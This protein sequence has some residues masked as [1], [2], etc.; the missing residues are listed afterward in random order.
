MS[1]SWALL[2]H[3]CLW[4]CWQ[5]LNFRGTFISHASFLVLA[6]LASEPSLDLRG[7]P[8]TLRWGSFPLQTQRCSN[9][10][11]CTQKSFQAWLAHCS[12]A[13]S[14]KIGVRLGHALVKTAWWKAN[15]HVYDEL[16]RQRL[17]KAP[18]YCWS[19]ILSRIRWLDFLDSH[20]SLLESQ[21]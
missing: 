11:P 13:R 18:D 2:I 7:T 8:W 19:S 3:F 12:S 4:V 6:L 10:Y 16:G 14:T 5:S 15:Y 21:L 17:G 9:E 20:W 1:Q